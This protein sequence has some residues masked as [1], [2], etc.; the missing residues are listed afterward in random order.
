VNLLETGK[1]LVREVGNDDLTGLSAELAY[2]LM[3]SMFPFFIFLA[4]LGGFVARWLGVEN[5]TQEIMDEVGNQL[6]DDAS[7]VLESQL[8]EVLDERSIGLLSIGA[9]GAIWGASSAMNTIIKALNR[10][11]DVEETRPLYKK[12]PLSLGLTVLAATF[13][14]AA[15]TVLIIGQLF[16]EEIGDWLGLEGAIGTLVGLARFPFVGF[17]LLIAVAFLY[18]A[19]PNAGLPFRWVTPGA[20]FFIIGWI[21]ASYGFAVYVSNFGSY[22]STYGTLGGAVI[23]MIWLYI[24]SFIILLGAEINAL[25]VAVAAPEELE[26][27]VEPGG[28]VDQTRRESGGASMQAYPPQRAPG[29]LGAGTV[30]LGAAVGAIT[31]ARIARNGRGQSGNDA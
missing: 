7:G 11:Y 15:F 19:A 20:A 8:R 24:T 1:R 25:T 13:F 16:A 5:P 27:P 28:A 9:L 31:A 2:R 3:L 6:P 23:L 12:L 10:A 14:V 18:W 4:A 17:L 30:A 22:Q 21:A 26:G 29:E